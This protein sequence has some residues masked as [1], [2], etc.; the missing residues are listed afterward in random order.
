MPADNT[1]LLP[2]VGAEY[3]GIDGSIVLYGIFADLLMMVP[4]ILYMTLTDTNSW[5][6][7]H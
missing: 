5:A 4:L 2:E 7:H 1:A 6:S 3:W